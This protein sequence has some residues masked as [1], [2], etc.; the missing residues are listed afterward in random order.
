MS[1]STASFGTTMAAAAAASLDVD[2]MWKGPPDTAESPTAQADHLAFVYGVLVKRAALDR[3]DLA[4]D[5]RPDPHAPKF[6]AGLA[7]G[8]AYLRE[9]GVHMGEVAAVFKSLASKDGTKFAH[10]CWVTEE[11]G[12]K[13]RENQDRTAQMQE[14]DDASRE[15]QLMMA[16]VSKIDARGVT[17]H[18]VDM[19]KNPGHRQLYYARVSGGSKVWFDYAQPA[20]SDPSKGAIKIGKVGD[21][22]WGWPPTLWGD[23]YGYDVGGSKPKK[24]MHK[25]ANA[26]AKINTDNGWLRNFP[27]TIL[28]DLAGWELEYAVSDPTAGS[29]KNICFV[30]TDNPR[31]P[32]LLLCAVKARAED[33][34]PADLL[35]CEL[36][37]GELENTD[38]LPNDLVS[39][40]SAAG[41]SADTG[42][43]NG[44]WGILGKYRMQEDPS[45]QSWKPDASVQELRDNINALNCRHNKE[46]TE[47]RAQ[48]TAAQQPA[49][50]PAASA[51]ASAGGFKYLIGE[52]MQGVYGAPAD[53]EGEEKT[54]WQDCVI[55]EQDALFGSPS[56][57]VKFDCCPTGA[58]LP[59]AELRPLVLGKG[60]KR[61]RTK[62]SLPAGTQDPDSSPAKRAMNQRV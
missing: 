22:D 56:Y 46:V 48:L 27:P 39:L 62:S 50:A 33:G 4:H 40:L 21:H 17:P 41:G 19:A 53:D 24:D 1:A 31:Y 14:V 43:R 60:V 52:R 13:G 15:R 49:S 35:H 30:P 3:M 45:V 51:A 57:K 29:W 16:A 8:L 9:C 28:C 47:L 12:K 59:E 54:D 7:A 5:E 26:L 55:L 38:M 61:T 18:Y 2:I 32:E 20:P 23:S 11:P 58:I 36:Q 42:V 37:R 44:I 10:A 34:D 6:E 25:R